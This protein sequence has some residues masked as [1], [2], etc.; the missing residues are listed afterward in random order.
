MLD[1]NFTGSP[2]ELYWLRL[3]N[4]FNGRHIYIENNRESQRLE[5]YGRKKRQI[6]RQNTKSFSKVKRQDRR[7]GKR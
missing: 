2:R 3:M 5:K 6:I 1:S 7:K 4:S